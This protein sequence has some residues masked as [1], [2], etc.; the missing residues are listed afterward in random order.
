MAGLTPTCDT[1]IPIRRICH[2]LSVSPAFR[3]ITIK[4]QKTLSYL[5]FE[6]V[7][8]QQHILAAARANRGL[9]MPNAII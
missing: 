5:V 8:A 6:P 2:M 9:R 4:V 1:Q 7:M 3:E